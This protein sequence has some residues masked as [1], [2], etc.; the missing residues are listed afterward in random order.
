[1]KEEENVKSEID[2]LFDEDDTSPITLLTKKGK[3]VFD[4]IALIPL[5]ERIFAILKPV[6]PM[7]DIKEDEAL[8]YEIFEGDDDSD[9]SLELV[10]DIDILDKVFAVYN[11]LMD[12]EE[13]KQRIGKAKPKKD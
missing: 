6:E 10:R 12:E 8:V 3:V 11:K 1:M 5:E 9:D 4:Q 7:E 2:K 13:L